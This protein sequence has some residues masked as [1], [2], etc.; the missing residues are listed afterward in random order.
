MERGRSEHSTYGIISI[1]FGGLTLLF[2][3]WTLVGIL[4][5]TITNCYWLSFVPVI[6]LIFFTFPLP[7]IGLARDKVRAVAI[8]GFIVYIGAAIF[9]GCLLGYYNT[10]FSGCAL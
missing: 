7:F 6:V 4:M 2:D 9:L 1:A 8:V 3:I 10:H 5:N